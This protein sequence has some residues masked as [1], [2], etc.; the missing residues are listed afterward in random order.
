[1]INF[2]ANV[3]EVSDLRGRTIWLMSETAKTNFNK[4]QI[5]Q[6][7]KNSSI[8][9]L[10]ISTIERIGGGS[11]RCMLAGIHAINRTGSK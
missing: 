8:L 2:C 1:M 6:L 5:N 3:L 10:P 9:A 7:T 4:L 11:L